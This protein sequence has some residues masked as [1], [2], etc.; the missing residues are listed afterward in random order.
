M[1]VFDKM[2]KEAIKAAQTKLDKL[3]AK[4]KVAKFK[5]D[6]SVGLVGWQKL[7]QSM[8]GIDISHSKKLGRKPNSDELLDEV[9]QLY[10][11]HSE[12]SR[13]RT[14]YDEKKERSKQETITGHAPDFSDRQIHE[15]IAKTVSEKFD[16]TITPTKIRGILNNNHNK[17][18]LE[19][20]TRKEIADLENDPCNPD[21]FFNSTKN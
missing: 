13:F 4:N 2:S 18:Q 12:F 21:D 14:Y 20:L 16:K 1:S 19:K 10:R 15:L 3:C 17:D 5:I 9:R 7:V 6:S 11:L 8:C